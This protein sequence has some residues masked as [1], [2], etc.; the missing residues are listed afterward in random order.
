MHAIDIII[1]TKH[2]CGGLEV[3]NFHTLDLFTHA[4]ALKQHLDKTSGTAGDIHFY[5]RS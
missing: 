1:I 3:Q 4:A 5:P 2:I